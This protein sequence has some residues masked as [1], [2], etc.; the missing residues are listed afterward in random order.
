M[1]TCK[2]VVIIPTTGDDNG[3]IE[4]LTKY[5]KEL[6]NEVESYII[7]QA[8]A[9]PMTP[10][11]VEVITSLPIDIKEVNNRMY[12]D[13]VGQVGAE[14]AKEYLDCEMFSIEEKGEK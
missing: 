7:L 9:Y 11:K 5:L 3:F 6:G 2:T 4:E 8:S 1:S 13:I 12:I 10:L 14:D